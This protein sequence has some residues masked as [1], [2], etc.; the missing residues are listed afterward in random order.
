MSLALPPLT[1]LKK[2]LMSLVSTAE[3]T[4]AAVHDLQNA[5]INANHNRN[6][7]ILRDLFLKMRKSFY[8]EWMSTE[9]FIRSCYDFSDKVVKLNESRGEFEIEEVQE[10]LQGLAV[11]LVQL[12][13]TC[14]GILSQH[15]EVTKAF[16]QSTMRLSR[17]LLHPSAARSSFDSVIPPTTHS[18]KAPTARE[19]IKASARRTTGDLSAENHEFVRSSQ[20]AAYPDGPKALSSISISLAETRSSLTTIHQLLE[21]VRA[22][23]NPIGLIPNVTN[24]ERDDQDWVNLRDYII[25]IIP[26]F[27]RVRDAITIER[28]QPGYSV[29]QPSLSPSRSPPTASE[30]QSST[31]RFTYRRASTQEEAPKPRWRFWFRRRR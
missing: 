1:D 5:S 23:P 24:V 2:V 16:D 13:I 27:P 22:T 7:Q 10:Y 11:Q 15:A 4:M 20:Q 9:I 21:S 31:I 8:D 3:A 19:F 17:L 26:F 29:R 12:R 18:S 28:P 14:G 25:D 6:S 30:K